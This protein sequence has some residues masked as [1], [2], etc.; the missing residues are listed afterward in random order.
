MPLG[1][2]HK[3]VGNGLFRICF[4]CL[5]LIFD[6]PYGNNVIQVIKTIVRIP[7]YIFTRTTAL[8]YFIRKHFL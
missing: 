1:V 8:S 5:T 6:I 3:R 7:I 2:I 4:I